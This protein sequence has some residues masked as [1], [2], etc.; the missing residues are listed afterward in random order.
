MYCSDEL[1]LLLTG[2]YW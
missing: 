2:R 1:P